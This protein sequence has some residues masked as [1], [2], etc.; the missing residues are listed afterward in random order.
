MS[1]E[2]GDFLEEIKIVCDYC[3]K[4]KPLYGLKDKR[5]DSDGG[6]GADILDIELCRSCLDEYMEVYQ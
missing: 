1:E 6:R 5:L 4:Q 3:G 2:Y